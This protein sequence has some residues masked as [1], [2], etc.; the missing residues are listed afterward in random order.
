[1]P[2]SNTT[3]CTIQRIAIIDDHEAVRS[4]VSSLLR[5]SG[6]ATTGYDC[7]ESLLAA[8]AQHASDCVISDLQMPGISG[9]ELLEQ[10]RRDGCR[11][12]LIV[13]TAFPEAAVRQR[14]LQAGAAGFLSKPFQAD[15]L[16]RCVALACETNGASA[17]E[18]LQLPGAPRQGAD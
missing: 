12:P 6:Y 1:M 15:E 10:L 8:Q 14:A 11:V 2:V 16:L 9:V 3:I 17:V 18:A 5:S 7:A 13:L 4:A